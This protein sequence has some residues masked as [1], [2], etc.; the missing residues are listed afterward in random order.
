MTILITLSII[1]FV[2]FYYYGKLGEGALHAGAIAAIV[3]TIAASLLFAALIYFPCERYEIRK[4]YIQIES[5]RETIAASR[6]TNT[7]IE[8]AA[9]VHVYAEMNGRL[10]SYKYWNSTMFDIWIPDYIMDVEP[11]R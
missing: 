4:F 7:P 10:A 9:L 3:G 2:C 5:V 1:T 8:R 6:T 11:I